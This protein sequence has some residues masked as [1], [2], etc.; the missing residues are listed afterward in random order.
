[1][2]SPM[3]FPEIF[4][5]WSLL[6]APINTGNPGRATL[7]RYKPLKRRACRRSAKPRRERSARSPCWGR[8]RSSARVPASVVPIG[9]SP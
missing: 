5:W 9:S 7:G 1:M 2:R 8:S 6:P 3:A 4:C